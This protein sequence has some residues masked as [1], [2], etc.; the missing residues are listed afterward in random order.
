M[1]CE[2]ALHHLRQLL[3]SKPSSPELHN[4]K[5]PGGQLAGK[6]LVCS[7]QSRELCTTKTKKKHGQTAVS[8]GVGYYNK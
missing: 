1:T 8:E 7:K 5:E 6:E 3:I 4:G 2:A